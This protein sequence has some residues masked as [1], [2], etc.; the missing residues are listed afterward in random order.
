MT[1]TC[2]VTLRDC[3]S[4]SCI[5]LSIILCVPFSTFFFSLFLFLQCVSLQINLHA[6]CSTVHGHENLS[7]FIMPQV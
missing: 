6:F 1:S 4:Y 3:L 2:E 7:V 5:D